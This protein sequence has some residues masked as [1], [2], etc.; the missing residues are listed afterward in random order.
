MSATNIWLAISDF[1][2]QGN[3]PSLLFQASFS[4]AA[5]LLYWRI[6][7]CVYGF[8][9]LVAWAVIAG[10]SGR[11]FRPFYTDLSYIILVIYFHL[12]VLLW[13]LVVRKKGSSARLQKTLCLML[14][15]TTCCALFLDAVFW[16]LIYPFSSR[17]V[18]FLE[19]NMHGVNL[20]MMAVEVMACRLAFPWQFFSVPLVYSLLYLV[21]AQIYHATTGVWLYDFL[22]VSK[23][24]A[25]V[26]YV[27]VVVWLVGAFAL[28]R[29]WVGLRNRRLRTAEPPDAA[30]AGIYGMQAE[31]G[32]A[33]EELGD[34]SNPMSSILRDLPT[35][36]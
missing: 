26:F 11:T 30:S 10:L 28:C 29:L 7:C 14:G 16:A 8:C 36:E 4:S 13:F 6:A 9:T 15:Q 22:N 31:K 25:P 27:A 18:D 12:H 19:I 20:L 1:H 34:T 17:T 32:S 2:W 3:A 21:V 35:D 24:L 33:D 23:P 5:A